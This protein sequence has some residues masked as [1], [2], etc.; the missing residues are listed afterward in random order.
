DPGRLQEQLGWLDVDLAATT[1]PW[2]VVFFHR[3][4]YSSGFEHGSATDVQHAFVPI[5]ERRGV[6]LVLSS[7]DHDYERSVP[8]REDT[9]GNP[10][11]YVVTG[12][13]GAPLYGVGSSAWTAKSAS[14]YEYV[15]MTVN[16]CQMTIEAVGLDGAVVDQASIN[17]C[18]AN[19]APQVALMAP[20]GGAS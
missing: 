3:S 16:G 11:T 13:G 14:V 6:Q 17:R 4:P 20:Q 5:F 15:R 19:Q 18:A 10:V 8:W 9:N 1:Q 2:R 7:H 12:G